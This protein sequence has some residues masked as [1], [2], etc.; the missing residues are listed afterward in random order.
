MEAKGKT[1]DCVVAH[2][3]THG[4]ACD[5]ASTHGWR[6]TSARLYAARVSRY[7]SVFGCFGGFFWL[8]VFEG[9]Y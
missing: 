8:G 5:C 2:G 3:H 9:P 7:N 6:C 1:H 4:R